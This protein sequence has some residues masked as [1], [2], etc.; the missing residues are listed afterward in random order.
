MFPTVRYSIPVLFL[1]AL[2]PFLSAGPARARPPRRPARLAA[3]QQQNALQQQQNAV[4]T[5]VQQTTLALQ[6]ANQQ[7]GVAQQVA[8]P[9]LID[10]QLQQNARSLGNQ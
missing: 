3:L 1:A 6:S 10:F 8:V 7:S 9:N 5:A 2:V 4:Q